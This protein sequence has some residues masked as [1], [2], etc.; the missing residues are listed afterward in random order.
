MLLIR[1]PLNSK[2]KLIDEW[3]RINRA[4][5][6]PPTEGEDKGQPTQSSVTNSTQLL[7]AFLL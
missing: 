7:I 6:V 1:I 3:L 5:P 4:L 2:Q